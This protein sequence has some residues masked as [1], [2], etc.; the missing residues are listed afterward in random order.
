M[1]PD[2]QPPDW[3]PTLRG[4][5]LTV[6]PLRAGDLAALHAASDPQVWAQHSEKNRHEPQ[7]FER[8]FNGLLHSGG[9]VV[10]EDAPG[11][12]IGAS[13]FYDWSPADASVIIGYTFLARARWGDGTN[14]ELK[15]LMLDHA[16]RWAKTVWFQISEENLRS[17]R[18]LEKLGATVSHQEAVQV[19]GVAR[20]RFIYRLDR[21]ANYFR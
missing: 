12:L 21:P 19:F 18:A 5:R 14:T 7:L 4:D 16:F 6:R 20:P 17:R 3:Q 13:K 10:V 8:Y 1:T 9:G 11:H 2:P 15:R